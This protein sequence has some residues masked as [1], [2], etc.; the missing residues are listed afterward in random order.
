MVSNVFV[1]SQKSVQSLLLAIVKCLFTF[2]DMHIYMDINEL[3]QIKD[4]CDIRLLLYVIVVI[5]QIVSNIGYRGPKRQ[6]FG[7]KSHLTS[8]CKLHNIK[9]HNSV[10]ISLFAM[11]FIQVVPRLIMD[12]NINFQRQFIHLSVH[13]SPLLQMNQLTEKPRIKYI[14]TSPF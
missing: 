4:L 3:K 5:S 7:C 6:L 10:N 8:E 9:Y 12:V 13:L 11:N 1:L 2:T 14:Y